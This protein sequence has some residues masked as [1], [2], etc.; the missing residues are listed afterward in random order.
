MIKG[1]NGHSTFK[2]EWVVHR[3]RGE[4]RDASA[5]VSWDQNMKNMNNTPR[6]R[7]FVQEKPRVIKQQFWVLL[8]YRIMLSLL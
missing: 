2:A 8:S 6:S 1:A 3:E 7:A 4:Q 5:E